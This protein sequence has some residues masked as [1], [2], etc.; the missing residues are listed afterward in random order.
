LKVP[1][2]ET[3]PEQAIVE[4]SKLAFQSRDAEV[5]RR[6]GLAHAEEFHY[7]GPDHSLDDYIARNAVPL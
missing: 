4:Y 5:G 3:T 6:H 1:A 2:L 7:I